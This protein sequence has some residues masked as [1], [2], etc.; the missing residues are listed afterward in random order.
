MARV[1]T[2]H[3]LHVNSVRRPTTLSPRLRNGNPHG[4]RL[5][6]DLLVPLVPHLPPLGRRLLHE[7]H[8]HLAPPAA[9][10]RGAAGHHGHIARGAAPRAAEEAADHGAQAAA[11][12]FAG[13]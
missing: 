11:G 7:L 9:G 10:G 6:A 2:K 12:L 3:T 1:P 5:P 4:P 13:Q 8:R